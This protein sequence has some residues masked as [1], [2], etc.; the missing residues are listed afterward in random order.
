MFYILLYYSYDYTPITEF[1]YEFEDAINRKSRLLPN[2]HSVIYQCEV[3]NNSDF[4]IK[5]NRVV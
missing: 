2:L 1:F 5:F 4:N 3:T